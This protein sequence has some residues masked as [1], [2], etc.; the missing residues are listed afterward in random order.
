MSGKVIDLQEQYIADNMIGG[1]CGC[2]NITHPHPTCSND[3]CTPEAAH[4]TRYRE[5]MRHKDNIYTEE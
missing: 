3:T 5:M 1:E 4:N 2:S